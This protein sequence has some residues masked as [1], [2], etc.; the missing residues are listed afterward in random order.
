MPSRSKKTGIKN[1]ILQNV[2][3]R[4][5][6]ETFLWVKARTIYLN[7]EL[8]SDM[9]SKLIQFVSLIDD[10]GDSANVYINS[11]GGDIYESRVMLDTI[12]ASKTILNII[13]TGAV[14]SSA[15]ELI[16]MCPKKR[17]FATPNTMFMFHLSAS[18]YDSAD[19]KKQ[20]S[21]TDWDDKYEDMCLK[22]LARIMKKKIKTIRTKM[23]NEWYL[24]AEEALKCNVIDGIWR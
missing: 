14:M 21:R 6:E 15:A 5:S 19:V 2:E 24:S 20:K 18:E 1:D 4:L 17:R 9:A 3:I 7:G 13:A 8:N 11:W 12:S 23:A 16:A 10:G 22:K